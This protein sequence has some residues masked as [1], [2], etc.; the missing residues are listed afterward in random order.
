[1]NPWAP[2]SS[3]SSSWWL[4][5]SHLPSGSILIH[6]IPPSQSAVAAGFTYGDFGHQCLPEFN[7]HEHRC[8]SD[9]SGCLDSADISAAL[10]AGGGQSARSIFLLL[11]FF[12]EDMIYDPAASFCITLQSEPT[13]LRGCWTSDALKNVVSKRQKENKIYEAMGTRNLVTVSQ[14]QIMLVIKQDL[15]HFDSG[16]ILWRHPV[17]PSH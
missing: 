9:K 6:L 16:R 3:S 17:D 5:P 4:G 14:S 7:F 10:T 8:A 15:I 2:E 13:S 1:M 11:L 12:W